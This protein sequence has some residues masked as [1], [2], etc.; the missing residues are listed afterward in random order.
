V[1][2]GTYGLG[3]SWV[4]LYT[5]GVFRINRVVAYVGFLLGALSAHAAVRDTVTF[6]NVIP[7]QTS[8]FS[9]TGTA[10]TLRSSSM[11]VTGYS[12]GKIYISGALQQIN[13]TTADHVSDNKIEIKHP[14]GAKVS[15]ALTGTTYSGVKTFTNVPLSIGIGTT[16]PWSSAWEFR[17]INTFDDSSPATGGGGNGPDTQYNSV[18]FDFSDD[19]AGPSGT[20]DLGQITDTQ[21]GSGSQANYITPDVTTTATGG[22]V[23]WY[24]FSIG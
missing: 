16:P 3:F 9:G 23:H 11:S 20:I 8:G 21:T 5:E 24:K 14:N 22:S 4:R 6:T 15:V 13:G 19:I 7:A 18:T 1:K 12:L 2:T 17:F 10:A